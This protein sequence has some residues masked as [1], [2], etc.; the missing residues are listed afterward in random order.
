MI[1]TF[2]FKTTERA[3]CVLTAE[4]EAIERLLGEEVFKDVGEV[5]EE[6]SFPL[7]VVVRRSADTG[8]ECALNRDGNSVV[9]KDKGI[10]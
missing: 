9:R 10:V 6:D 5:L 8:E 1:W 3:Y 4:P 2:S 7:D